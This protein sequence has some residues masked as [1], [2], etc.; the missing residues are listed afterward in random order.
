MEFQP[1]PLSVRLGV[2]SNTGNIYFGCLLYNPPF[3]PKGT[4]GT[5]GDLAFI[6]HFLSA[7]KCL[8]EQSCTVGQ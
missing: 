6:Q 1:P 7:Q 4:Q 5:L 3:S 8:H 2:L